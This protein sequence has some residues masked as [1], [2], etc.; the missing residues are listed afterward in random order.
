[1]CLQVNASTIDG[2][3]PLFNACTVGSVA[4]TEILLENGAKPQS[5]VY[6]PSPIHEATSKGMT[7]YLNKLL[8]QAVGSKR[9]IKVLSITTFEFLSMFDKNIS[10]QITIPLQYLF[11][12]KH[13]H[14][15]LSCICVLYCSFYQSQKK[16]NPNMTAMDSL[17]NNLALSLTD[18]C[19]HAPLLPGHYGCVEALVTWGA[20]VDMDIPHLGTALYTACVCQEL[21]CARKL[22]REGQLTAQCG[23]LHLHTDR[24]TS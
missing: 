23:S 6:H 12:I 4:C 1:M 3:S 9:L 13:K 8:Q 14:C 18:Y 21:E 16:E 17:E 7:K 20:D 24:H 22:L 11:L 2:V 5:L 19:L 15:T 10:R